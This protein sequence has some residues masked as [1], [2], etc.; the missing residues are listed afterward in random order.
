[1]P[2]H[3][4]LHVRNEGTEIAAANIGAD[5]HASLAV[6]PENLVVAGDQL[7]LGNLAQRHVAA[8]G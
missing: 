5:D 2:F 7:D 1:M 8:A 4:S 3:G 6:L